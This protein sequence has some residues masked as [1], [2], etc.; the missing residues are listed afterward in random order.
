MLLT[1]ENAFSSSPM[2]LI[3]STMLLTHENAIPSSPMLLTHENAFSS[4]PMLLTHENSFGSSTNLY[5]E[6]PAEIFE[7]CGRVCMYVGRV[8]VRSV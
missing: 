4:Y 5:T 1:H 2:L 7:I 6:I 8:G 3:R